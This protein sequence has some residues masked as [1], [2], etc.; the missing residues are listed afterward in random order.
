L[1]PI[2][3]EVFAQI[4]AQE[5]VVTQGSGGRLVWPGLLRK[6]DRM[7]ANYRD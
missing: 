7:G 1:I 2:S 3:K 4:P 6:L 5:A